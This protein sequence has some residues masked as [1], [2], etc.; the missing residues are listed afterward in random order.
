MSALSELPDAVPQLPACGAC[1]SETN[2]V[3]RDYVYC[4]D[5]QLS[6]DADTFRASFLDPN[7]E[8][9]GAACDN[10]WHG[11]DKIKPGMRF[12]CGTCLLPAGHNPAMHWTGCLPA[13]RPAVVVGVES[14][15][16]RR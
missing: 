1:G 15:E 16:Q 5:C 2:C 7:A 12:D 9:C 6:F 10:F 14:A 8:P 13:T 4:E 11:H 3:E